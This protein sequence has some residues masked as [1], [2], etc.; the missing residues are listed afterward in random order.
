MEESPMRTPAVSVPMIV[1]G[2]LSL[3]LLPT[4]VDAQGAPMALASHQAVY[5][6]TLSSTRGK[7][8]LQS[9]RGRIYYDFSGSA[10]EG[11]AVQFR[12]A[13]EL[14][15]GEGKAAV[16][17][18]RATTW[19]DGGGKKLSFHTENS[20]DQ[21]KR[22]T[23]DGQAERTEDGMSVRL[24][25]PNEKTLDIGRDLVFP[26][27]HIRRIVAA[28]KAGMTLL[29]L[30]VYDGSENG[31]KVYDTLTVIG[32]VVPPGTK[33]PADAAGKEAALASV[34]RWPVT[35]S[36]FDRAAKREG[37]QIPTYSIAF[38]LYENGVQRGLL[39]DYN[40]FVIRGEM[41]KLDMKAG[42]PC[43]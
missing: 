20:M 28:A 1:A 34:A 41:S 13:V 11:Y 43:P 40:D 17:E 29:E 39:L 15:N 2:W 27:E 16:N 5:D 12:Q 3:L 26:T 23:V 10:C 18:L 24:T 14:D 35:I 32:R 6:L 9:V 42:K 33:T 30:G 8:T 31:E 4:P 38:E 7:S 37:E 19:E 22:E 21:Q 36:Y 25:K